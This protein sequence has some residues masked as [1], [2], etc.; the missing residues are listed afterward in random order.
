MVEVVRKGRHRILSDEVILRAALESFAAE[1]YESM[2]VRQLN[3]TL[4][5]SHETVRQRFGSKRELYYAVVDFGIAQFFDSLG[6]ER[7]LLPDAA[8][9]LEELRWTTRSFIT[10]SVRFPQLMNIVNHEAGNS[11]ERLDYIFKSGFEQG[12]A[13]F[14]DLLERLAAD[15]VIYPITIREAYFIIDAGMSP[16]A[17]VGLSRAFDAI[18]G[19]L[20]QTAHIDNFLDF[21]LRGLTKTPSLS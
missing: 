19:P 16:F 4:G 13:L 10:A 21:I 2:S 5:L 8:N 18:A 7:A 1:G 12:M 17:Q 15:G 3:T 11:S 20:D 14:G 9:E 6:E